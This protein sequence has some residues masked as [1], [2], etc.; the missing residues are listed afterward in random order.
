MIQQ[1]RTRRVILLVACLLVSSLILMLTFHQASSKAATA[2]YAIHTAPLVA[3]TVTE[4]TIPT[5]K[6]EPVGITSGPDGNLWFTEAY[7][8]KIGKITTSGTITE[9]VLPTAKSEPEN[10]TVGPDGNLWFTEF[11]EIHGNRIGKITT[12]GTITEYALPHAASEPKNI[13]VGPDG[14][15]W[16]TEFE[17]NRIGTITPGGQFTEYSLPQ[18]GSEPE[19]IS[20]GPCDDGTQNQC[21]W[22]TEHQLGSNGLPTNNNT[23]GRITTGGTITEYALPT[24]AR[25]N[26][27]TLG[28][29][30][31]L[32]FTQQLNDNGIVSPSVQASI[33]EITV[34]NGQVQISEV[35]SLPNGGSLPNSIVEGSD[36]NLWFTEYY[37]IGTVTPAGQLTEYA[38]PNSDFLPDTITAGPDGNLW[39]TEYMGNR[40]ALIT[41]S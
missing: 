41:L 35:A 21:L 15:L 8:N 12:S 37:Q 40:I 33:G 5:T 30:G 36:G 18:V 6:S 22:F 16:F 29:N 3:G 17:G 13:V 11:N 9:Y 34:N 26:A 27:I 1:R 39:F 28:A 25:A 24:Y 7:G 20:S 4:Y 23:I 10:I 38:I 19:G 14:N 32:Y 31:V 2:H